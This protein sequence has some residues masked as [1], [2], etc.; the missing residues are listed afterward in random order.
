MEK[1]WYKSKTMWTG[2]FAVVYALYSVATTGTI[3]PQEVLAFLS[4]TGLIGIR[5]A[6]N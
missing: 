6:V 5:D 4:G 2:I 1:N 3:E